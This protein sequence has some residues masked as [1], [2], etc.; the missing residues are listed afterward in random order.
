MLADAA[1][2]VVVTEARLA[3]GLPD[4]AGGVL[5]VDETPLPPAPSPARGEG[6]H[7]G[8]E[9]AGALPH[10]R[11]PALSHSSSTA[12]LIYTSGSTGTPKAVA[13]SHGALAATMAASGAAF[14]FGAEDVVAALA[15]PAFDISLWET[16]SPLLAGGTALLVPRE[17][18]ADPAAVLESVADATVLHAVPALMREMVRAARE[19][20]APP[21]VRALFVGG[22]AVPPELLAEMREAFPAAAVHVLYGP[23]EAA[24]ICASYRVPREGEVVGHP[25]GS[26]LGNAALS[27]RDPRGGPSPLGVPGEL[28]IGGAGVAEGYLGREELTAEKFVAEDGARWYRTGD[29]ARWRAD[30]T[31]EW[32]G[33]TDRQVKLRGFRIEPGEVEAALA[34]LPEVRDAVVALREDRPG[35]RRLVAYVVPEAREAAA[36]LWPSIGEY[37]VYDELIYSGLTGDERRNARYRAALERHARGGVVLDVGTGAD[38]ILARIAVEAGARRVYAVELLEASYLRAGARIES[39]GLQDRITLIHGDARTVRLP[40]PVDVIVSEIVEAVAGGEG[41]AVVL[42]DARRHLKPGGVMVPGV[43]RTR[44]AAV[45][46]PDGLRADPRFTPTAAHY[47][48]RIFREVGRPFDV[49]LCVRGFPADGRVSSTGVF[50]ELDFRSGPAATGQRRRET[51]AVE[52]DGRIDGLLLW[53]WMELAPGEELDIL[54][55]ETAWFPVYFPAF[56]DGVEVRAGDRIEVECVTTLSG[57]GVAPDYSVRGVV[58]RPGRATVE[59][60]YASAHHDA[61]FRASPLHRRVLAEDGEPVVAE[62]RPGAV[63]P[64]RLRARLRESLPDYMVPSAFVPLD[65]L[66][67]TPNGKLD[68]AALPAPEDAA[69]GARE[70]VA[71]RGPVEEALAEIWAEVLGRERVGARDDFF[72]LGGHSLMA[73]QVI[74]RVRDRLG[75]EL[76]LREMFGA[77]TL[78]AFALRVEA[79]APAA[80]A[81]G[82]AG[83]AAP[84]AGGGDGAFPLSFAQ[85]RLWFLDQMEPE[86]TAYNVTGAFHLRGRLDAAALERALDEVRRRH[87]SLRTV[88]RVRGGEPVQVVLPWRP[89]PLPVTDVSGMPRAE[90]EAEAD[91]RVAEMAGTPFDLA[92]GP[93]VRAEL[94]RLDAGEHV[95]AFGMHH[96]VSDGWSMGVFNRELRTLYEAFAAGRASPLPE[97]EIQYPDF[98]VWQREQLAGDVVERQVAFWRDALGGAPTLDLPTDRPRPATQTFRGAAEEL[99]VPR[100]LAGRL[101]ALGERERATPFMVLMAAWQLLLARRSGQDDVVVGTPVA[102][103]SRREIEGLIGFFVNTLAIRLDLAGRPDFRELVRRSREASLAALAHQDLPFEKIVE[104]LKPERDP[105]RPPLF[106]VTFALQN[107]PG[108][109]VESPGLEWGGWG[110]EGRTAKYDLSLVLVDTPEG[111]AGAL[112]Y[113]T[114]L[115]ERATAQRIVAQ[116]RTVLEAVAADPAVRAGDLPLLA[117]G[118]REMLAGWSG[119]GATQAPAR[120]VHELFAEQAARTPDAVAVASGSAA[121]TYAE[122]DRRSDALARALRGR[123]VRPET[124]VALCVE[125][126]AEMVAAVLGI[127]RAGGVFVPLDPEYPAERLAFMLADSGARLL[128]TDGA[129]GDALAG[130]AGETVRLDAIDAGALPHSRTP[131]LSHSSSHSPS[132]ENLAYVIY[133]SGST[134]TP[135]G[136]AV[137]HASLASTLLSARDA[138]G[139]GEGDVMP[140]LASFAFDIWLL[141]ALLPLLSGGSVRVVPRERVVDVDALVEELEGATVLH[142]VPALM[143]RVVDGVAA[144]RGALPR[145]RRALVGGDAVPPELPG[146]MRE[147]FPGAEVRLLYGP[148]EGTIICAAHHARGAEAGGRHLLGRPLGNAPLYVLDAAGEPAPVGVPG[149]LC[150][151]GAATARGYPGR[152][153]ATAGRFVPDALS[154][155]A[156]ARMYRSGDRARWLPTGDLE[157]LGRMD[158][159]VKVRGFRIEPGEVE[160][161]LAAHPEVREAV[162]LVREDASGEKRLV[163]YVVPAGEGVRAAELREHLSARLPEYMVPGTLVVLETLPLT[164]NGKVDRGALPAPDGAGAREFVPPRTPTEEVVAGIW[165][166]V[167]RLERVGARDDFFELGGHSLMATQVISRVRDRLGSGVQLRELFQATTLEAFARRVDAERAPERDDGPIGAQARA[168]RARRVS[169]RPQG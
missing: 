1:P 47:V 140:S 72:A 164:P 3:A 158:R 161:R 122:L 146:A 6:E 12:Y 4:F 62:P 163:G 76:Q 115:F 87:D 121:L 44:V 61:P 147:V 52:R 94:V 66:P 51:L 166:E 150:I 110:G 139:I 93:L 55:E 36:E 114:D 130:F 156:G 48:R 17:R 112:E 77:S 2:K 124:P 63:D 109:A 91:R 125:R 50:E 92:A 80:R 145:L 24:V 132:P 75:A 168:G 18:V 162:V 111:L 22:D 42:N 71:P 106:Q 90:R 67:L 10:S 134:G 131:A 59:F 19:R 16:L 155:V 54:E 69:A 85:Q 40:E 105:S 97:L 86:S 25:I 9:D 120:C 135:K 149:E 23:T 11:T 20:G 65:S 101:R 100:E 53:L 78:E 73:T 126:S 43:C 34:R 119:S 116:L 152:P 108:G 107:A 113:N 74:S 136:V 37:F 64:D 79:A 5:R 153:E 21:R 70:Y 165:A 31:L 14:G 99:L 30:G 102:G 137:T 142:A 103:R 13:V 167:L 148:T 56:G 32:M 83:A 33:R 96:I 38:A 58:A 118:E 84:A 160:A 127:L 95:F 89:A 26:P 60:N 68:R 159:Q 35:E 46:L 27:V 15:S 29:R 138:F 8:V 41:A 39:L 104:E 117:P 128:L 7:D 45:A 169:R 143:R 28:W 151:A 144:A 98:A 129:A 81:A 123:G 157:F 133:T 88:F 141:E 82:P 49:R 154:G 57:N